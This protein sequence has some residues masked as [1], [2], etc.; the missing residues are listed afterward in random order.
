MNNDG[1]DDVVGINVSGQ[2]VVYLGSATP[3]ATLALL[4]R[5]GGDSHKLF[6]EDLDGDGAKDLIY[7]AGTSNYSVGFSRGNGLGG[8]APPMVL[9]YAPSNS[10]NCLV[11]ADANGDGLKDAVGCAANQSPTFAL[12]NQTKIGPGA[13]GNFGIIPHTMPGIANA[14]SPFYFVGV[15]GGAPSMPAVLGVSL[16]VLAAPDA[17]GNMLDPAF[18]VLPTASSVPFQTNVSGSATLAFG[19][20]PLPALVGQDDLLR[21]GSRGR[22]RGQRLQPD[23]GSQSR[24]LV[25]DAVQT[26]GWTCSRTAPTPRFFPSGSSPHRKEPALVYRSPSCFTTS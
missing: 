21:V 12:L 25:A 17:F 2:I 8:F 20:P 10:S 18:L 13:N 26:E 1:R 7:S 15:S 11:A 22:S 14:G 6:V 3:F 9:P 19:L 16:A 23:S 5:A 4:L 24:V